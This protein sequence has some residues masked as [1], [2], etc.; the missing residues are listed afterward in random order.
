[1]PGV[2]PGYFR[3]NTECLGYGDPAN[4]SDSCKLK[5]FNKQH[6][7]TLE[8]AGAQS[9]GIVCSYP[10]VCRSCVCNAHNAMCNRHGRKPP[11]VTRRLVDDAQDLIHAWRPIA[12]QEYCTILWWW[13]FNWL[14][15]WPLGKRKAI[16]LSV[17]R[18]LVS[19]GRV[20]NMVKREVNPKKRKGVV[21]ARCIQYYPTL[22]TQAE[23]ASEFSAMQKAYAVAVRDLVWGKMKTSLGTQMN[24]ADLG[25]WAYDAVCAPQA[26]G[27]VR[28]WV[29]CDM[30]NFDSTLGEWAHE[31][32]MCYYAFASDRFLEFVEDSACVRGV[33]IDKNRDGFKYSLDYTTKSGHNDTTC[34]NSLINATAF[35]VAL[36]ADDDVVSGRDIYAG[37]DTLLCL[38]IKEGVDPQLIKDRL[39]KRLKAYGLSP[40]PG[41]FRDVRDVTFLSGVFVPT[42]TGLALVPR[43]GRLLAKLFWTVNAPSP[44]SYKKFAHSIAVGLLPALNGLAVYDGFLRAHIT[45]GT[46][47]MDH[48]KR[49]LRGFVGVKFEYD[50]R[51][52]EYQAVRYGVPVHELLALDAALASCPPGMVSHPVIDVIIKRD[53]AAIDVRE[54]LAANAA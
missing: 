2:Y 52:L 11:E 53:L 20:K 50:D 25:N 35:K 41:V 48:G 16:S 30:S 4:L 26:P 31:V 14:A 6:P 46:K 32:K 36:E 9:V 23:V 45:P 18:D 42:T 12:K 44:Q 19:P 28:I 37:D 43:L 7:C 33:F 29:E 27:T 38:D 24:A 21:K 34:G 5:L 22:A 8:Q 1:M 39:A 49:G 17:E 15:K 13:N 51:A 10:S 3:T 47:L 54:N 40:E